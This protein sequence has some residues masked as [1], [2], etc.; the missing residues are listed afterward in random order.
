M[1]NIIRISVISTVALTLSAASSFA[2]NSDRGFGGMAKHFSVNAAAASGKIKGYVYT[3]RKG[4]L[5]TTNTSEQFNKSYK[6]V[7][8]GLFTVGGESGARNTI[9]A[10]LKNLGGDLQIN[11][12]SSASGVSGFGKMTRY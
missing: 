11:S 2:F 8:P 4:N 7:K 12:K 3:G 1:K 9:T 6:S 5:T 10:K